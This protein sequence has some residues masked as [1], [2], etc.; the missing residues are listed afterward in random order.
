MVLVWLEGGQGEVRGACAPPPPHYHHPKSPHLDPPSNPPP[1]AFGALLLLGGGGRIQKQ[2]DGPPMGASVPPTMP[3]YAYAAQEHAQKFA[4]PPPRKKTPKDH[5]QQP[6]LRFSSTTFCTN[7]SLVPLPP[8]S[9]MKHGRTR[10]CEWS[11]SS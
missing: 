11:L 7:M 8:P 3:C 10:G 9:T 1:W 2:G 6:T 5:S 4:H